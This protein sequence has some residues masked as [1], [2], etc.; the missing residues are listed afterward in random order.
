MASAAPWVYIPLLY[1]HISFAVIAILAGFLAMVFRKGSELHRAAGAVF[2]ASMAVMALAA[3]YIATFI[4]PNVSNITGAFLTFYLVGTAWMA[5]RRRERRVGGLDYGALI[6][7]A[8]F[9]MANLILGF[10]A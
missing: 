9:G 3:G 10:Q 2:I 8:S 6:V 5:G 7:I 4:K 1:T